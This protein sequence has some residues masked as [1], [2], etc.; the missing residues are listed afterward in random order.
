MK[1]RIF[2]IIQIGEK[3]DSASRIFDLFIVCVILVHIA[4]LFIA[5]FDGA[6]EYRDVLHQLKMVT[7]TIFVVEYLL[8]IWTA[9]FL[10]PNKSK[11]RAVLRFIFSF[12]GIV[13]LCTIL[14]F[15]CLYGF[16][17]FRLLRVVRIFRLFRINEYYDSFNVITAVLHEKKN[18]IISCIFI[19]LVLMTASSLCMYTAEHEAQPEVFT[20]AF[21]GIWWSISTILTVGYG[22]IYPVTVLG[23]L[24]AIAIS[25]LGVGAVAIPTG[26][27]SAGFV[28]Q[29]TH[30]Q[31]EH[32]HRNA[33]GTVSITVDSDSPFVGQ[34]VKDVEDKYEMDIIAMVRNSA[35]IVPADGSKI[36]V[37]DIL[38][39]QV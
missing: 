20:N 3:D 9:E 39:Y 34:S 25:F 14:Q 18:Q 22:D 12:D 28:E 5:T 23:R 21:S 36:M 31:H 37:G 11:A 33:L 19:I 29:Y 13:D 4:V 27:I 6:A 10:Y 2:D 8:R 7:I 1:K 17:A 32:V 35:V 16:I 30:M 15:S 38:I 24:M 26:I